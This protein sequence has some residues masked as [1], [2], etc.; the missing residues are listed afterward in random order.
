MLEISLFAPQPRNYLAARNR[1][2][3]RA[4]PP[5]PRLPSKAPS[6]KLKTGS[7]TRARRKEFTVIIEIE[8]VDEMPPPPRARN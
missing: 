3:C 2:A 1:R 8:P 5:P 4:P 7:R 6:E